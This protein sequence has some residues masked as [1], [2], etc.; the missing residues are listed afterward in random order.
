MFSLTWNLTK[1]DVKFFP[2]KISSKKV[3]PNNMDFLTI[4]ITSKKISGNNA[5]FWP[6]KLH[7][8]KYKVKTWKFRPVKLRRK[9]YGETM[10]IFQSAKLHRTSTW[11]WR[12]NLSK[13]GLRS[14]DVIS[15]SKRQRFDMVCPLGN[16]WHIWSC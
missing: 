5:D 1:N 4:K 7:P 13:F 6:L 11:K 15:T 12:G 8:K 16:D 3:R 2:I 10:W 14:I 9:K